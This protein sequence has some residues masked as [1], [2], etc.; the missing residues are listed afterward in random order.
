MGKLI[1]LSRLPLPLWPL[2]IDDSVP[3]VDVGWYRFGA[4]AFKVELKTKPTQKANTQYQFWAICVPADDFGSCSS[5]ISAEGF[6][7]KGAISVLS[8]DVSILQNRHFVEQQVPIGSSRL[9][10][11]KWICFIT[12]NM[13]KT[14]IFGAAHGRIALSKNANLRFIFRALWHMF[15]YRFLSRAILCIGVALFLILY[16]LYFLL[17]FEFSNVVTMYI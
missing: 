10:S 3:E 16:L 9:P 4:N 17:Y 6:I 5:I 15:N 13:S 12:K 1:K 7:E 14:T 2:R 8:D 11:T